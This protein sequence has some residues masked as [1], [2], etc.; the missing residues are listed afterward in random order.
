MVDV[1]SQ[2]KSLYVV[3]DARILFKYSNAQLDRFTTKTIFISLFDVTI[4][5]NS[6][7]IQFIARDS[8]MFGLLEYLPTR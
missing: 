4:L 5:L 2:Y 6:Y 3:P 8:S 7:V 1:S